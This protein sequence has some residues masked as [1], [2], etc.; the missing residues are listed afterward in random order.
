MKAEVGSVVTIECSLKP[1]GDF[2]P[3]P[4]FDGI[5]LDDSEKSKELRFVLGQG[6][7]LPGLHEILVGKTEGYETDSLSLDAGWG[8]WN[9]A[10]KVPIA[11]ENLGG[12]DRSAIKVGVELLMGNGMKA[13]VTEVS[14]DSF[15]VDA[16]PPLAGASY[17]A[18]VKLLS[19]EQGPSEFGYTTE[20]ATD[21]KFQVATVALGKLHL[22]RILESTML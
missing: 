21:S 17:L 8:A 22:G 3:E 14:E 12:I 4:L 15:T 5:V 2:V 11:F 9:P 1:E 16:N 19:V 18:S 6:N 7:Y 20:S 10:L 13:V